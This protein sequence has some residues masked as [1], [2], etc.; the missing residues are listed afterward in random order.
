MNLELIRKVN[1]MICAV[2]ILFFLIH[3]AMGT[4]MAASPFDAKLEF[5]VWGGVALLFVHMS[6]AIY[7]TMNKKHDPNPPSKG[8]HALQWI[9]GSAVLVLALFHIGFAGD[10]GSGVSFVDKPNMLSLAVMVGLMVALGAHIIINLK[11]M[12]VD[13]G[14]NAPEKAESVRKHSLYMGILVVAVFVILAAV[15]IWLLVK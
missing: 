13:M 2:A 8:K 1:A 4:I 15:L 9:T 10:A 7:I 12:F 6:T 11:G 3:G 5:L 14:L